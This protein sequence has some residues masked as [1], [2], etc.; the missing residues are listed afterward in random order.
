M[1][2]NTHTSAGYSVTVHRPQSVATQWDDNSTLNQAE[3]HEG[4]TKGSSNTATM[5]WM[6]EHHPTDKQARHHTAK[7]Q[8]STKHTV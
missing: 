5:P 1:T 2:I 6:Q 4:T 7:T 8:A 3:W